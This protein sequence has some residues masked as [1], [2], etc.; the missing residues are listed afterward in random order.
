MRK[1]NRIAEKYWDIG[2]FLILLIPLSVLLFVKCRYGYASRDE[3][4]YLT[5]PYRLCQEDALLVN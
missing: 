5:I 3:A 2:L 1:K 4:F